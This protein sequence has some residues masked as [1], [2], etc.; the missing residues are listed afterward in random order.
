MHFLLKSWK[1][2]L[3]SNQLTSQRDKRSS[4]KIKSLG[5]LSQYWKRGGGWWSFSRSSTMMNLS[6]SGTG[7]RWSTL[8]RTTLNISAGP[9]SVG[10][11][12]MAILGRYSWWST[13]RR[14]TWAR[15]QVRSLP[16]G[17]TIKSPSNTKAWR[18]RQTSPTPKSKFCRFSRWSPSREWSKMRRQSEMFC[19]SRWTL[20]LQSTTNIHFIDYAVNHLCVP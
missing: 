14:S 6:F 16:H 15:F 5:T 19:E 3:S 4:K 20:H 9:V 11:Q 1:N 17:S 2:L 12:K 10:F 18:R 13:V 8:V 7:K